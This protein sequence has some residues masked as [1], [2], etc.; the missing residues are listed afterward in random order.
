MGA[1]LATASPQDVCDFVKEIGIVHKIL[2]EKALQF[3]IDGAMLKESIDNGRFGDLLNLQEEHSVLIKIILQSCIKISDIADFKTVINCCRKVSQ[4]NNQGLSLNQIV[5]APIVEEQYLTHGINS[6][7]VEFHS[8]PAPEYPITAR[9]LDDDKPSNCDALNETSCQI[10]KMLQKSTA[11]EINDNRSQFSHVSDADDTS[12]DVYSCDSII[13]RTDPKGKDVQDIEL[14]NYSH[15][16]SSDVEV[17]SGILTYP[18][19]DGYQGQL[20]VGTRIKN[21]I[22]TYTYK[23]GDRYKGSFKND[24]VLKD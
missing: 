24:K 17:E 15:R 2:G 12:S 16:S 13:L 7:S 6:H 10:T 1:S 5:S 18:N 20:L 23:N 21:G 8:L 14:D 11:T 9:A 4:I 22:G 19:G 3:N